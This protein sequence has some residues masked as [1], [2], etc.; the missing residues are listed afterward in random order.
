MGSIPARPPAVLRPRLLTPLPSPPVWVP[1]SSLPGRGAS[2]PSS[3]AALPPS[4]PS[5]SLFSSGGA[6][7]SSSSSSR[8]CRP[9]LPRGLPASS[10]LPEGLAMTRGGSRLA[11]EEEEGP[12]ASRSR[13]RVGGRWASPRGLGGSAPRGW[14]PGACWTTPVSLPPPAGCARAPRAHLPGQGQGQGQT[15]ALHGPGAGP[16]LTKRLPP[17]GRIRW[18]PRPRVGGE[19]GTGRQTEVR[20]SS[21]LQGWSLWS[22]VLVCIPNALEV[23]GKWRLP[24]NAL[25]IW[26]DG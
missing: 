13:R 23:A 14:E 9:S 6:S 8:L 22:S 18:S 5:L 2:S 4:S 26:P 15:R 11:L 19:K 24:P 1:V 16:P 12:A 10:G 7:S 21:A 25:R 17:P 20:F 3:C